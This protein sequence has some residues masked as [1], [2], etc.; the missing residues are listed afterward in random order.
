M[1]NDCFGP[2]RLLPMTTLMRSRSLAVVLAMK[3]APFVALSVLLAV[4]VSWKIPVAVALGFA[5]LFFR[6]RRT[7]STPTAKP[8]TRTIAELLLIGVLAA[9]VGGLLFGGLGVIFG[10]AF[11]FVLRLSEIPLTPRHADPQRSEPTL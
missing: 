9:M 4:T 5:V 7:G 3:Y 1:S 2:T 10:F 6:V 8:A 11:G